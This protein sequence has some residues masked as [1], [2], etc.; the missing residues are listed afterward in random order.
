ML[1]FVPLSARD[2]ASCAGGTPLSGVRAFAAT[3]RFLT[4]FGL[5][6]PDDEDAERT[7]LHVAALDAFLRFGERLVAVADAEARDLD[8]DFGLVTVASLPFARVTALFADHA[9]A[10]DALS[11]ALGALGE[12]SLEIAW[13]EPAH[14]ALMEATDLLWYGPEEWQALA[15]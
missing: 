6:A 10:A 15:G 13:D 12:A 2:L 11:R 9:D 8:D 1:V 7:L 3:P 14:V 4:A 5:G